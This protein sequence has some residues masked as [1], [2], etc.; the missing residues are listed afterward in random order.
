[1]N[2]L[3]EKLRKPITEDVV[4]E[5]QKRTEERLRAAI[6]YLGTRWVLHPIHSPK[7]RHANTQPRTSR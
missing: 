1:M 2:S 3:K 5:L 6:D 4:A 7:P